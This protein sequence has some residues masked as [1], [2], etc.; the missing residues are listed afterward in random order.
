[1]AQ[2]AAIAFHR[3]FGNRIAKAIISNKVTQISTDNHDVPPE[4][5]YQAIGCE[6]KFTQIV[7]N[8]ILLNVVSPR[9]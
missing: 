4:K 5:K 8:N 6:I 7:A 3:D 2:A 9:R 1:M